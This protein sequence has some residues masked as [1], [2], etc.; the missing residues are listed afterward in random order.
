MFK[1][2]RDSLNFRGGA[3]GAGPTGTTC[4]CIKKV[5]RTER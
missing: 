2:V 1:P 5:W 3:I 4:F